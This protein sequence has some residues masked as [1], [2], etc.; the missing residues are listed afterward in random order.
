MR[1]HLRMLIALA[2]FTTLSGC[3]DPPK[4]PYVPVQDLA[5]N[6][7]E[8]RATAEQGSPE[9][10]YRLG[11][12]YEQLVHHYGEAA[13]W[14]RMAAIQ[15]HSEAIY[16]LCLLSDAGRGMPQDFQEALRWCHL[17]ADHGHAQA[18]R[19]IGSYFEVG[20]GVPKDSVQAHQWY[21]LAAANGDE[22]GVKRR[23]RLALNMTPGQIAQA[24][25]QARS[26]RGKYQD[27]SQRVPS[28]QQSQTQ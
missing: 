3:I 8:A 19:M 11:L 10:Q 2:A 21:N 6:I 25:Y 18:M 20:R 28:D 16:R 9:E 26:W 15:Q 24:Q 12:R 7:D 4:A 22:E 13:R 14:Y 17:A 1:T 27:S 23:N 5:A